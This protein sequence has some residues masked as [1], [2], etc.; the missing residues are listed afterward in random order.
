M[1][2]AELIFDEGIELVRAG[3]GLPA[4]FAEAA[5]AYLLMECADRRD[6][7]DAL[8]EVLAEAAEVIDANVA[9]AA[10]PGA[11]AR[12]GATARATPRR[13]TQ[14]GSRSS[15]TSRARRRA[16]GAGRRACRRS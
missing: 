3:A 14:P 16:A 11:S 15:S 8:V 9:T 2:A 5:P 7:T 4:P 10:D 13:S 12:S 1:S 6:P